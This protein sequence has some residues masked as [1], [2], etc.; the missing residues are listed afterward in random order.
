M[1]TLTILSDPICPWCYIGKA[2][3]D[4]AL[5]AR[6][7]HPFSIAWRPF[8]L[9]P[10]MPAEGVDRR[11]Y[12]EAKFGGPEGA[13]RVYGAIEATAAGD[14]LTMRF[15]RIARTPNTLDAHRAI[16]WARDGAHQHALAQTLFER[17]FVE[18]ADIGDRAVLAEAANQVGMDGAE[19]AARLASDEDSAAVR[20][21]DAKARASGVNGVPAFVIDG[22][23]RVSGAQPT[24]FWLRAIDEIGRADAR[25]EG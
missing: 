8:Q 3:L 15:D 10:D 17:Y 22:R 2:R 7:Y 24:D 18:G 4:A 23:Y 5:A 13:A 20:A 16:R 9:N 6:A 1:V 12:L 19:I 25:R 11:S 14:G 21:E